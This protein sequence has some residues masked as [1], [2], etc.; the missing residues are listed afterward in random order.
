MY[1]MSGTVLNHRYQIES[2]LGHGGFGITY[3]AHDQTLQVRVAIKE[4]LPR[5]LATRGEGQ[6]KVSIF[7]GE[8][9][10]QYDYGLRKF[11]EEAQSVAR[12]AHHPN[13]VSARDYFEANGTAYMVMEYVEGVTLKEYLEKKGGRISFEEAKGI[14]MP[15]M[16]AL[17]EVHQ[18]GMLHRDVSPDNIY[19]TTS[20]QVKILD[21]GAARYFA[22]EQSKSLSVILKPGYAPEE[23]YRSSGKQGSWTDVYSVGATLYKALTGQ[24][25]PDALDRKEEDTLAPPSRLGVS[26][27]PPAEQAL[28]TALAVD[29]RQRFQTMGEF[30]QALLGEASMTVQFQPAPA[31]YRP[32]PE[33]VRTPDC[34]PVSSP[35]PVYAPPSAQPAHHPYQPRRSANPAAIAAGIGAGILGIALLALLVWKLADRPPSATIVETP[36]RG[37][38]GQVI[39]PPTLPQGITKGP[40]KEPV[41]P[42]LPPLAQDLSRFQ[43][44]REWAID[45]Q[46][47]FKYR[48]VMQI[49]QQLAANRYLGRITVTFINP[50]NKQI[51][52]SMDGLLTVNGK[53]V[54]INCS[55]ASESWWDTDDFYLEWNHDTMTGYNLDKRGRRGHAV[56][57]FVGGH[58]EAGREQPMVVAGP[59]EASVPETTPK[60][61]DNPAAPRATEPAVP[62]VASPSVLTSALSKEVFEQGRALY[63]QEN[64]SAA[65]A[66]LEE[67]VRLDPTRAQAYYIL[68]WT[69]NQ[70]DRSQEALECFQKALALK[71]DALTYDGLAWTYNKLGRHSE[72][73]AAGEKAVKLEFHFPDAHYNLGMAYLAL[74]NLEMARKEYGALLNMKK[75]KAKAKIRADM[76][77]ES[78]T[79]QSFAGVPPASGAAGQSINGPHNNETHRFVQNYLTASSNND[80]NTV[81]NYYAPVVDYFNIG[82]VN[83]KAI[84]KD[85][86]DYFSRW[87]NKNYTVVGDIKIEDINMELKSVEFRMIFVVKNS[88]NTIKGIA[89]NKWQI[90][91]INNEFK[92]VNEKQQVVSREKF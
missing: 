10:Q 53:N 59:H 2:V 7:T 26:I 72:A 27:L 8:A 12:F 25:P 74:G 80:L 85:K 18:A 14:M 92:I 61:P 45:W 44:G 19:I 89:D 63:K 91:K 30:Q 41:S 76:L 70:V 64:Y 22:G 42:Q 24:T 13:V 9:R 40:Q 57:R 68:G 34:A 71:R 15:V 21:F 83:K 49:R 62:E 36:A 79:T 17:R 16:D 52:V 88:K 56:F 67:A 90:K 39:S 20:A 58:T 6:T 35:P 87:P 60:T 46:S 37:G 86:I 78:I 31:P 66:K 81:L 50:K 32:A 23:Q 51:T 77:R 1:L 84:E 47:Q 75:E 55:N 29:A 65:I 38:Q 82:V 33:P 3:A 54:V 5:Q 28:M 11:L 43:V 69:Y 4:Y 48:G 73:L